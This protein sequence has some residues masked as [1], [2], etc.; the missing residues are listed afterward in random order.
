MRVVV[1]DAGPLNYLVLT[2]D[3]GLLPKLFATVLVPT[4]V[5]DELTDRDTPE[6]VRA[7]MSKPP[8]WLEIRNER[9]ITKFAK[10]ADWM[11][12]NVQL[13]HSP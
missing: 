12:V 7:W 5:R 4:A 13:S 9:R 10:R 1:A 11:R 6:A 2:G 3:I 8:V